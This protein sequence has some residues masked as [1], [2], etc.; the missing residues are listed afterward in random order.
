MRDE[1][2]STEEMPQV[3]KMQRVG[4]ATHGRGEE[5]KVETS[6]LEPISVNNCGDSG[7]GR[8]A[9]PRGAESG[10]RGR[11]AAPFSPDRQGLI[12]AWPRLAPG[13]SGRQV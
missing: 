3:V 6:G 1:E 11:Q 13:F 10:A 8:L 5:K 7:L 2:G 9:W 4:T 12:N